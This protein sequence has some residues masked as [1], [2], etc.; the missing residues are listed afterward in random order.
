M[1]QEIGGKNNT[2]EFTHITK[3]RRNNKEIRETKLQQRKFL[4][5]K[6]VVRHAKEV[7]EI[8]I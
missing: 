8:Y 3:E 7:K 5:W 1:K 6:T 2:F 4:I